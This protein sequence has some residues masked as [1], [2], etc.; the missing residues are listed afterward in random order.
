MVHLSAGQDHIGI[1]ML[2]GVIWR[3]ESTGLLWQDK[4]KPQAGHQLWM[5]VSQ[6]ERHVPGQA[7]Q[8]GQS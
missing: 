2:K 1:R 3:A 6:R 5:A 4:G 8:A 7:D